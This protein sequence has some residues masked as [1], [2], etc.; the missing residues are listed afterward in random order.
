MGGTIMPAKSSRDLPGPEPRVDSEREQQQAIVEDADNTEGKDREKVH[1][2][3][4]D[5]GL[6]KDQ[7]ATR[8]DRS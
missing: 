6:A 8:T 2:E 4:R 1:G 7:V 3:G 5:L